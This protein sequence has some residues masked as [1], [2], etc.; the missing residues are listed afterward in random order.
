[1]KVI[2]FDYLNFTR[3]INEIPLLQDDFAEVMKRSQNA[4]V[5]SMIITGGSLHES[6]EAIKL[7]KEW[8]LYATAGCHPTRSCEFEKF[9]TG[10]EGYLQALDKLIAENISGEGRV[11]A[12]GECG[13]GMQLALAKKYHLPL[14]LHSR[15]AHADFVRILKEEGFGDDG[16][17]KSGANGGVVHSFTGSP[18]E[19]TEYVDAPWCSLTSTHASKAHLDSLPQPLNSL[20]F[21]SAK[22]PEQFILGQAVKG[23]NE[24]TAI[25]GVAWVVHQLHGV[26][27]KTVTEKVWKNTVE[28]FGLKELDKE[29]NYISI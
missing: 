6:R 21:P 16:G 25:G 28:L 20:F 24:P 10:P 14:F 13:L 1:M 7:A 27:F 19:A 22:R 9:T 8:K 3:N 12:I 11:V 15:S 26:P 2:L 5:K 18:E 17:R 29:D 4:G 23:R